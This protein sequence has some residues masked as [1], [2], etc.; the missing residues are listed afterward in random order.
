MFLNTYQ[1]NSVFLEISF[2]KIHWYGF[3]ITLAGVL[4]FFIFYKLA[5]KSGLDKKFI[6]DLTFWLIIWGLIGARLYH[7]LSE[8][9]YYFQNPLEIFF[10][11]NGGLGIFGVVVAG[12]IV[13]FYKTCPEP[14]QDFLGLGRDEGS[15]GMKP[16]LLVLSLLTPA[17]A[18]GQSIGRWGNY[19]NQELYGLPSNLFLAIPIDLKNRLAGFE[20]F[21]FFH[22]VF[23]YE[24]LFCFL[25]AVFLTIILIKI[26][27]LN[28]GFIFIL[29]IFLYSLWR[30]FIEFLRID[31]QPIFLNLRLAQW[32]S[33]I[34]VIFAII[35][36]FVLKKWYNKKVISNQGI[37]IKV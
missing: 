30:F 22:P 19:F 2:V 15:R 16:F 33:L 14:R 23:L 37:E 27:N 25:M 28:S 9:N 36:F 4:G 20:T 21:N 26:K 13:I 24:S 11:W 10:I 35:F 34:F 18:L 7:I 12:L 29:Y 6:F 5:R 17:L 1:P 8:I 31:P 3:L 32:V